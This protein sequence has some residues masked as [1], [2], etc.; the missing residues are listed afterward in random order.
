MYWYW[1]RIY[2]NACHAIGGIDSTN[3]VLL[4]S[5]LPRSI[6]SQ[7]PWTVE[8]DYLHPSNY[9]ELGF[10]Y[11]SFSFRGVGYCRRELSGGYTVHMCQKAFPC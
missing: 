1:L 2:N 5:N 7:L 11:S 10:R 3:G 6:G 8:L 9:N 4:S